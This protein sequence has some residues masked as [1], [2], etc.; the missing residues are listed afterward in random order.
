[1][2]TDRRRFLGRTSLAVAG[3]ALGRAP[4]VV[5]AP[6]FDLVVRGGTVLDGTGAPARRVDVAGA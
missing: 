3:L 4:R 5:A 6:S 2:S 1:M